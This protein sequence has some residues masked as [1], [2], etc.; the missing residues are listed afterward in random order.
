MVDKV[1]RKPRGFGFVTFAD[2]SVIDK[3]FED[4]HVIDGR[5]VSFQ[6]VQYQ[7]STHV[8]VDASMHSCDQR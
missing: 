5:S 4:E 6:I 8:V 1:T 3:V 7:Y 2:P